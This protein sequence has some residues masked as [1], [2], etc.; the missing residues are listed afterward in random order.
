MSLRV[1]W[2]SGYACGHGSEHGRGHGV[3]GNQ[4]RSEEVEV[5]SSYVRKDLLSGSSSAP[6]E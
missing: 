4:K 3:G 6:S 5:K 1:R 2:R